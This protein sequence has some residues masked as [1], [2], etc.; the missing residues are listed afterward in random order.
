MADAATRTAAAAAAAGAIANEGTTLIRV[1]NPLNAP[2]T[3]L[4][5]LIQIDPAEAYKPGDEDE[6]ARL[7]QLLGH[8]AV[9][10]PVVL[11]IEQAE[12]LEPAALLPLQRLASGTGSVK[13]L[14]FGKPAFWTLLEGSGLASLRQALM[15]PAITRAGIVPGPDS[16]PAASPI[17]R[18]LPACALPSLSKTSPISVTQ[19]AE[20]W[21]AAPAQ[22]RRRWGIGGLVGLF[23]ALVVSA[24]LAP[25]GLF[26]RATPHPVVTESSGVRRLMGAPTLAPRHDSAPQTLM[27]VTKPSEPRPMQIVIPLQPSPQQDQP[28]SLQARPSSPKGRFKSQEAPPF[29][30]DKA[31]PIPGPHKGR[32]TDAQHSAPSDEFP[33]SRSPDAVLPLVPSSYGG[34]VVIHYRGE[35]ATG[36]AVNRLAAE[37]APFAATVQT[38]MVAD[39]PAAAEIRFFHRQDIARAR[40]L[41]DALHG[42]MPQWQVRDFSSYR[43]SPSPGTIEVWVPTR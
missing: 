34:R 13:L 22:S 24:V 29:A 11:V 42:P 39:T 23:I 21:I 1:G 17:G 32:S 40:E 2:L 25:G 19:M 4:R 7:R 10:G 36:N 5:L 38:R 20:R 16:A 31:P 15:A 35:L 27:T 8:R 3:L 37:A 26:Y 14:F 33:T 28:S 18:G 30:L 12:T 6:E 43:P 9:A 41:A